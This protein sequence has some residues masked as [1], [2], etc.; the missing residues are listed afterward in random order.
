[1]LTNRGIEPNPDKCKA[2]LDMQAP[3]SKK[4]VQQLTGRL[5]ALTRFL[6]R[7][8]EKALPFFKLLKKETP[9][10]WNADCDAAFKEIKQCLAT[11]PVLTNPDPKEMLFVYLSVGDEAI[12]AALVR[13]TE[14]GQMPIYF[15]SKALQSSELWYQKIEKVAFALLTT[16]RRLRQYFQGHRIVV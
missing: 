7:S 16:A 13:D 8:A 9:G 12:S 11:P 6:P 15:I 14:A 3:R 1:M 2:V 5:A 10:G 4:E